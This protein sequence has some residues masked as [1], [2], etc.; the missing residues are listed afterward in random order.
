MRAVQR[1][2]LVPKDRGTAIPESRIG[3]RA[4]SGLHAVT[5]DG[6]AGLLVAAEK[7][8]QRVGGVAVVRL[9]EGG[10]DVKGRRGLRVYEP[11]GH[12]AAVAAAADELGG[13]EVAEIMHACV[14]NT[15]LS[16]HDPQPVEGLICA[17]GLGAH[18]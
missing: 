6:V 15:I 4:Q 12:G 3:S 18:D 5:V 9:Q 10:V 7:L 16:T 11:A 1:R 8:T 13:D 17:G 14:W 2:P